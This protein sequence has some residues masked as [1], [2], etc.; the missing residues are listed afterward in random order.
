MKT[1]VYL[2]WHLD[3]YDMS[4]HVIEPHIGQSDL[5]ARYL[6]QDEVMF[7]FF[8]LYFD[9]SPPPRILL[10]VHSLFQSV[11]FTEGYLI[12]PLSISTILSFH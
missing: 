8:T 4:R 10:H 12:L 6:R 9:S 5:C 7:F 1:H 3:L 11:C 2:L